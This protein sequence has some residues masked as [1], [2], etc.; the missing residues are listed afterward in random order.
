MEC[1]LRKI[2]VHYQIHGEG[3]PFLALHGWGLDHR[4]LANTLEPIFR[5]RSGWKRIYPDLPGMGKTKAPDWLTASDQMLDVLVE[6]ADRVAPG[7]RLT[8]LGLSYGGYLAQGLIH[9]LRERV[10][11]V[12]LVV[13]SMGPP[14]TR[15]LPPFSV[16]RAEPFDVE[17]ADE[18]Q[19]AAFRRMAVVQT[20]EQ[21]ALWERDVSPAAKVADG[22]FL[23]WLR[24]SYAFSFD[25]ACLPRPF[26]KPALFVHGRQDSDCGYR[27]AWNVL[28]NYPR[29]TF[30]ALDRAGHCLTMEQGPLFAALLNEWLDRVAEAASEGSGKG[31]SSQTMPSASSASAVPAH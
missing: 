23:A 25:V 19:V 8:L 16:L 29:A 14:G 11:G 4:T 21:F 24:K 3:R 17:G 9:R 18:E 20:R 26:S 28:G 22:V 10:D 6:F 30:A 7:E 27:E 5:R 13:P 12:C 31:S 15:D 1:R 2:G